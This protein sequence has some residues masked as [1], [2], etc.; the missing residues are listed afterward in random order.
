MGLVVKLLI[1]LSSSKRYVG[2]VIITTLKAHSTSPAYW[3][4]I[5]SL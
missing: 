2:I 3:L 5:S 1:Q 4:F